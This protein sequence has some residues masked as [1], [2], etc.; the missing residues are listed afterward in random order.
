MKCKP[1]SILSK[2]AVVKGF[3]LK[4]YVKNTLIA[5]LFNSLLACTFVL[6]IRCVPE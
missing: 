4:I 3:I 5:A 2:N 1:L 6:L